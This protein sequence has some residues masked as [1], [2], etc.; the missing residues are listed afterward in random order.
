MVVCLFLPPMTRP[1]AWQTPQSLL[2]VKNLRVLLESTGMNL[3]LAKIFID[4][5][6]F[7]V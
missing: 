2:H 4:K 7:K 5:T 1:V 3:P 6:K